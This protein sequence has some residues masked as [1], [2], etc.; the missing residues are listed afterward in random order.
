MLVFVI[1]A[2]FILVLPTFSPLVEAA[3]PGGIHSSKSGRLVRQTETVTVNP[4]TSV[5]WTERLNIAN[6]SDYTK[7]DYNLTWQPLFENYTDLKGIVVHN[8]FAPILFKPNVTNQSMSMAS[9]FKLA[10]QQIMDGIS[11]VWF[12]LPLVEIPYNSTIRLRAY[13]LLSTTDFNLTYTGI[14]VFSM[15]G[16]ASPQLIYDLTVNP[17]QSNLTTFGDLTNKPN[18]WEDY[19]RHLNV[20][21]NSTANFYYNFTYLK[22]CLGMFP[23]EWYLVMFD[24]VSTNPQNMKV[25]W[26]TSDFGSDGRYNSWIYVAGHAYYMSADLDTPFVAIYGVSNGITGIGTN[27]NWS[28]AGSTTVF[29]INASIPIGRTVVNTSSRYFNILVPILVNMTAQLNHHHEVYTQVSFYSTMSEATAFYYTF[30]LQDVNSTYAYLEKSID[31]NTHNNTYIDHIRVNQMLA[32]YN[33][34]WPNSTRVKYWGVQRTV[35]ETTV[36]FTD[37]YWYGLLAGVPPHEN[38]KMSERTFFIPFGYY[39]LDTWYWGLTNYSLWTIPISKPAS[40]Q[41]ISQAIQN[42][43]IWLEGRNRTGAVEQVEHWLLH[44]I[45]DPIVGLLDFTYN[46]LGKWFAGG[47]TWTYEHTPL[48]W[49][50]DWFAGL[51]DPFAIWSFFKGIGEW[52]WGVI[53]LIYDALEWFGYWSVRVIYSFSVAL[54]YIINVFGVISINSALLSY[55]RT[56]NGQDFLRG[57]RSGWSFIYRI[58]A[59]L[60]SLAVLAVGIVSAVIPL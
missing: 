48:R 42:F 60:I 51:P 13:R 18:C 17:T 6:G 56:G 3:R 8:E 31:L 57:L 26:T 11:E 28:I 14:G 52:V 59:L 35:N 38:W 30:W 24:V 5:N 25:C 37:I 9:V 43:E 50:I 53:N 36:G 49:L 45:A 20:T 21:V 23:N 22:A 33:G 12:R 16:G 10:P 41:N 32:G 15:G 2:L 40:P 54:V 4:D 19:I 55:A 27:Q 34:A 39:G 1:S 44:L 58:I 47:F 29:C 7:L 46:T